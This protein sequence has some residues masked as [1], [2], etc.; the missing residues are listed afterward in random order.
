M[1][2][3]GSAPPYWCVFKCERRSATLLPYEPVICADAPYGPA[4]VKDQAQDAV[5]MQQQKFDRTGEELWQ[6]FLK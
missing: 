6:L 3:T 2:Y 5:L 4:L 1:S